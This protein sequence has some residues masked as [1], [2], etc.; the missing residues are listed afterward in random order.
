MNDLVLSKH[1]WREWK[2]GHLRLSGNNLSETSKW[3][4]F[5]AG[6]KHH[7]LERAACALK[8]DVGK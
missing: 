8:L 4:R 5:A 6:E 2:P 1:K 7:E 3:S